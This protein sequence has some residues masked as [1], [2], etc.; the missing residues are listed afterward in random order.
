MCGHRSY[1][2][3]CIACSG[4]IRKSA[5]PPVTGNTQLIPSNSAALARELDE[6]D[7]AIARGRSPSDLLTTFA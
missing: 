5:P 4:D 2:K 7:Q 6:L 3:I 1:R